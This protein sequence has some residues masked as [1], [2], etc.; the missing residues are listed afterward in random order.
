MYAGIVGVGLGLLIAGGL[1]V[2]MRDRCREHESRRRKLGELLGDLEETGSIVL[3]DHDDD[4]DDAFDDEDVVT[5]SGSS[6]AG[7]RYAALEVT[8]RPTAEPPSS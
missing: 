7:S 3:E 1:F 4:F 2:V 6:A 8:V 5:V